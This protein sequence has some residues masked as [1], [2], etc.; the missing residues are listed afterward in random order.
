LR[1]LL[2]TNACIAYLTGRSAGVLEHLQ[3]LSPGDATL[4]S[5]VKSELLYGARKSA[6]ATENLARLQRFFEPFE[7]YPFDD[8]IA[9]VAGGLRA[10]LDR[11]G[12]PIGPN[13]LLI[14]ATALARGLRLVTRNS[15]ELGRV[16]GLDLEDWEAED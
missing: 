9:A 13:D 14:C 8:E 16:P 10:S 2:D 11:A 5:V 15:K 12:T 7:S 6:R 1:Y 4:C 3:R